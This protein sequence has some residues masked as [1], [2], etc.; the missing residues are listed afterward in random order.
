MHKSCNAAGG[1]LET[2]ENILMFRRQGKKDLLLILISASLCFMT[3]TLL[4]FIFQ[5]TGTVQH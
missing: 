3:K 2:R 4:M 1:P 5:Q